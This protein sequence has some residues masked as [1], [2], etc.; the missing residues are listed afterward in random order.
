[1]ELG[2]RSLEVGVRLVVPAEKVLD[3][4]AGGGEA[5]AQRLRFLGDDFMLSSERCVALAELAGGGER[6]GTGQEQ[7]DAAVAG[8]GRREET[9][10]G[11]EPARGAR[12][13]TRRRR[14]SSF[15]Q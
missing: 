11:R 14:L 9:E 10:G 8:R 7:L 2:E 6:F 12:R 1:M 5:D 13:C 4:R 3:A 15:S